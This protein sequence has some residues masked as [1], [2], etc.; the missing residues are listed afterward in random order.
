MTDTAY[1][2]GTTVAYYGDI[3]FLSEQAE[4]SLEWY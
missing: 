3:H 1:A 2:G 4:V